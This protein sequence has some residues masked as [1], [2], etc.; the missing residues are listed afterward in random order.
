MMMRMPNRIQTSNVTVI[1]LN[2]V[3]CSAGMMA[4]AAVKTPAITA[5]TMSFG[6][7]RLIPPKSFLIA[8]AI[9]DSSM[10]GC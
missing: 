1:E 6:Q 8:F 2:E 9:I 7:V 4:I 5:A 3:L 10:L